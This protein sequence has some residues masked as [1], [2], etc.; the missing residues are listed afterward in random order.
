MQW[1]IKI[2]S[3]KGNIN[4]LHFDKPTTFK[5]IKNEYDFK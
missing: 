2:L 3:T 4:Y 1:N 5:F